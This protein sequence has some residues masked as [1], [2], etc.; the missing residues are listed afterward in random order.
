MLTFSI[1]LN[2]NATSRL[3]L[4]LVDGCGAWVAIELLVMTFHSL[5]RRKVTCAQRT[6]RNCTITRVIYIT[7]QCDARPV[8]IFHAETL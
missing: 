3:S 4:L 2:E 1:D 8:S 6:F 7:S 5:S